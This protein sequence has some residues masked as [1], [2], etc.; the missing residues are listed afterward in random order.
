MTILEAARALRARE[1][2]SREL[3]LEA[4]GRIRQGNPSLNAFITV[5]GES[6]LA[7]AR[8]MDEELDRGRDRGAL[9][10]IPVALKDVFL[11]K[12]V[13]TTCGSLL[14]AGHVPG[15]DAAVVERLEAAGAVT[16]GKTNM[17]ELAYGVTSENPHF[18]AVH[19]PWDLGRMAGGS[20]GGSAAAVAAGMVSIAMGSDTGGSIRIPAAF[21]GVV[22]LKPT[23][24]R[25]SR[26][27]VIPLSLSLDHMGPLT[28]S[29]RD[30]ALVLEATAGHDPRDPSSSRRPVER[31][32]PEER[33]S[34]RD[35]RIGLAEDWLENADPEVAAAV[36]R[37]AS[38]AES[39]GA[40]V[41]AVRLP[42]MDAAN[43]AGRLILLVEAA[44]ILERDL[45]RRDQ[46][47]DD[48]RALLDQGRLVPA[49]KYVNAQRL[50]RG[51][52]QEF[53][54]V[55]TEADCLFTPAAPVTAP[56]L[57]AATVTVRGS[58]EDLRP[59]VTRFS[60]PFNL[61]G[62]PALSMPCGLDAEGLPIGLQMVGRP[63]AEATVLR[64]AAALEDAT[65]IAVQ[66]P[67]PHVS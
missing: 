1:C 56:R 20:S 62:L 2:S 63:F 16:V 60:R 30:A 28:R 18:G 17:H 46:F 13:R 8:D 35:L 58:T 51:M 37:M 3:T 26:H 64:V 45:A 31:Y 57:G 11:T 39:L 23:Y 19:N 5:T 10:G 65:G 43:A 34:I 33:V 40:R 55:W 15:H 24:G 38:V 12:G 27:G 21:C 66:A 14:F 48:V 61:L 22:G 59:S 25:V 32:L 36:R 29:V 54:S 9:H 4:L 67:P 52:R 44:A 7:R 42:D 6:A 50:R 41:A 53:A 49:T 47:G